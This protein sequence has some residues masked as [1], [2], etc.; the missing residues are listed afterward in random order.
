MNSSN[1]LALS[2][3]ESL[4]DLWTYSYKTQQ[5]I[6]TCSRRS[7]TDLILRFNFSTTT[8]GTFTSRK[9]DGVFRRFDSLSVQV[10]STSGLVAISFN[11]NLHIQPRGQSF[12]RRFTTDSVLRFGFSTTTVGTFTLDGM[13]KSC[14]TLRSTTVGTFTL[15]PT[16]CCI[17]DEMSVPTVLTWAYLLSDVGILVLSS[18]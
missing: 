3:R 12:P 18:A 1:F 5:R 8:V 9:I 17:S 2:P 6:D 7:T 10:L 4:I 13:L 11:R 16:R 15:R 14:C